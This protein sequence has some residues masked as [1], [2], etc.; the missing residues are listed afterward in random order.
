[1][2]IPIY[3]EIKWLKIMPVEEQ[4][5]HL[6]IVSNGR[7][8][9]FFSAKTVTKFVTPT[10]PTQTRQPTPIIF[11]KIQVPWSAWLEKL[12]PTLLPKCHFMKFHPVSRGVSTSWHN[13]SSSIRSEL[14]NCIIKQTKFSCSVPEECISPCAESYF[15]RTEEK[16]CKL[17]FVFYL[18]G[19]GYI[20]PNLS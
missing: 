2:Y 20:L 8:A 5:G 15:K 17:C 11:L 6:R 18:E 1:M 4:S 7:I 10:T 13:L 14:Q 12:F 16:S 9:S 3:S 19:D